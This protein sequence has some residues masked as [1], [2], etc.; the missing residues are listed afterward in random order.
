MTIN[1]IQKIVSN[2]TGVSI[3]Q[4][5]LRTRKREIVEARQLTMYFCYAFTNNS[6]SQIG[7]NIGGLDHA[8]VLYA[9]KTIE[10][11]T[12]TNKTI[13]IKVNTI[14]E[15]IKKYIKEN[16]YENYSENY[17][18]AR[19]IRQKRIAEIRKLSKIK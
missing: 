1:Q 15:E 19:N 17:K 5:N 14:N 8:T 16:K 4:M 12:L 18:K 11:L 10:N 7:L 3:D 9:N 6:L 2:I 13:R